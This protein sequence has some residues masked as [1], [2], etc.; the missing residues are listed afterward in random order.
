MALCGS[1]KERERDVVLCVSVIQVYGLDLEPGRSPD[2]ITPFRPMVM[3]TFQG[4]YTIWRVGGTVMSA[5]SSTLQL[6]LASLRLLSSVSGHH[7]LFFYYPTDWL[8]YQ[9]STNYNPL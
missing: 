5:L 9:A 3:V 1:V 7:S 2:E 4:E 6:S 8:A